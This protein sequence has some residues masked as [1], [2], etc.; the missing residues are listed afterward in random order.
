MLIPS[1]GDAG[2]TGDFSGRKDVD[3]AAAEEL[4]FAG[5]DAGEKIVADVDEQIG[6]RAGWIFE[7]IDCTAARGGDFDADVVSGRA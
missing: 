5:A 4:I 2:G 7:S 6:G 1:T 3:V